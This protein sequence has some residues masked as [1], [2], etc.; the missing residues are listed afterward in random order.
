MSA[1]TDLVVVVRAATS[2]NAG[3]QLAVQGVLDM[4]AGAVAA[5]GADQ[6]ALIVKLNAIIAD[7]GAQKANLGG[8]AVDN[9][10]LAP[11]DGVRPLAF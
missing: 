9:A 2:I 10:P 1:A 6:A 4:I 3:T 8:A 5:P 11:Q 7:V